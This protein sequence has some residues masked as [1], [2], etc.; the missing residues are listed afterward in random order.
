MTRRILHYYDQ[1][2]FSSKDKGEKVVYYSISMMKTLIYCLN[3]LKIKEDTQTHRD[4]VEL[5]QKVPAESANDDSN[6]WVTSMKA[7]AEACSIKDNNSNNSYIF[8]QSELSDFLTLAAKGINEKRMRTQII[9]DIIFKIYNDIMEN[10]QNFDHNLK[11]N[12]PGIII[13]VISIINRG[14][15][16]EGNKISVYS[17]HEYYRSQKIIKAQEKGEEKTLQKDLDILE[18][19]D[20]EEQQDLVE[21]LSQITGMEMGDL[22]ESL[23]KMQSSDVKKISNLCLNY[24]KLQ[25]YSRKIEESQEEFRQEVEREL[26]RKLTDSQ[27]QRAINSIRKVRTYIKNILDGKFVPHDT[28]GINH[29]KHNLEYGFQLMGL[30]E[31][32]KRSLRH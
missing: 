13:D 9:S 8:S 6:E 3:M 21:N 28:H 16:T 31:C 24:T 4:A 17:L 22:G 12:Y 14:I 1:R 19:Y 32:K 11:S 30:I 26:G 15:D 2:H 5:I 7:I 18:S 29:V 20:K 25:K 27:L 10:Y 23:A